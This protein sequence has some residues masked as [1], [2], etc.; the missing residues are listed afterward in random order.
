MKKDIFI[1]P[2][3]EAALLL[4]AGSAG[5]V[6]HQPL[7][8]SSL[9]PTAYE[10]IEQPDRP[11]ARPYN[12]FVG[13]LIG[14]LSGFAGLFAAHAFGAPGVTTGVVAGPRIG[15]AVFAATLTVLLTLLLK[16]AQ[17]AAVS[18]SL[19]IALGVLQQ[20]QDGFV[21]M[22]AVILLLMCGEPLR[23]WRLRERARESRPTITT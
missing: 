6:L 7:L 11:S 16:A 17:P 9:G 12:I 3:C 23:S 18:T 2:V 14:V 4:V 8:F 5:W 13:H 21:I 15:A 1:A 22:G 19:L 10:L 20:R